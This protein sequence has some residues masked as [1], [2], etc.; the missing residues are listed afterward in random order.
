MT[1]KRKSQYVPLTHLKT[2]ELCA[3]YDLN[4]FRSQ[5]AIVSYKMEGDW[6]DDKYRNLAYSHLGD[7]PILSVVG[8]F[9]SYVSGRRFHKFFVLTDK[10]SS[11]KVINGLREYENVK[12]SEDNLEQYNEN[13][14]KRILASLTINSIARVK[15]G[16]K[17]YHDGTLLIVNDDNFGFNE[18]REGLV[19]LRVKIDEY[20]HL[21]GQTA[22]FSHPWNYKEFKKPKYRALKVSQDV[23]GAPWL[24]RSLKPVEKWGISESQF[25][26]DDY[27]IQKAKWA[28]NKNT[29]PYW[30]FSKD[31]YLSG[32]LFILSEI[33]KSV[34]CKFSGLLSLAFRVHDVVV[35]DNYSSRK[36]TE[37]LLS[38]ELRG[39]RI[40]FDDNFSDSGS[41]LLIEDIKNE[42]DNLVEG[43][44]WTDSL[45]DADMVISLCP[46]IEDDQAQNDNQIYM[47][48]FVQ[49]D[50]NN[51]AVQHFIFD[52][53]ENKKGLKPQVRRCLLDLIVK[54][55]LTLND[56]PQE[57][58]NAASGWSF[59]LYT[60]EDSHVNGSVIKIEEGKLTFTNMGISQSDPL[61]SVQKFTKECLHYDGNLDLPRQHYYY[62]VK[63]DKNVYLIADTDEIPIL[64]ADAIDQAYD[65]MRQ[66]KERVSKLKRV[67]LIS[68]YLGPYAGFHLWDIDN[69][70]DPSLPAFAYFAGFDR[71][72][73]EVSESKKIDRM[74]RA[75]HVLA[76]HLE[77]PENYEN[78][79]DEIINMLKF[80]LGRWNEMMTYPVAFKFLDEHLDLLSKRATSTPWRKSKK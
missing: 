33:I 45:S 72:Y 15:T 68:K 24:G 17:M 34:N 69:S 12:V 3:E 31:K 18:K 52:P 48:T 77:H 37:S 8:M 51:K 21:I 49:E 39:K 41:A 79:R 60:I 61:I 26:P 58:A 25:T 67:A 46:P 47:K 13:T 71:G 10:E 66:N 29:I 20:L 35:D 44:C 54:H 42:A 14:R 11:Q 57:M 64:D 28:D 76:L 50:F 16:A 70:L 9:V 74:H 75:R 22:T 73:M 4:A 30:A 62:A 36:A 65:E 53:S 55:A 40:Y 23:D 1:A 38:R 43:L 6:Y 2:N 63:K 7:L 59:A 78:D 32:K 56:I 5:Y 80:G 27:F 19:C